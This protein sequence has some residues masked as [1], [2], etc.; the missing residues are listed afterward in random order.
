MVDPTSNEGVMIAGGTFNGPVAGGRNARA[1]QHI[2]DQ[3]TVRRNE[4]ATVRS[5]L[6]QH[7]DEIV[8]CD[9]A[10]GDLV[11]IE[12]ESTR[13]QPDPDRI[14]AAL[15]RLAGRVTAVGAVATAVEQLRTTIFG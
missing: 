6:D 4:V 2:G 10:E 13:P 15:G 5:L 1:V 7:R 3:A 8:E 12:H 11:E 9:A 14:S